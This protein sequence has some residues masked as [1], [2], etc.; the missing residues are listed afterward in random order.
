VA[1]LLQLEPTKCTCIW[2]RGLGRGSTA[3]RSLG[4]GVRIPPEAGMSV[5]CESCVLSGRGLCVGLITR[6]RSPT[7]Y[8]VS[9]C[10]HESSI[11]RRPWPTRG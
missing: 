9:E 5:C 10:D 2:P 1:E 7:E 3:A 4:L 11:M 8:G 6:Q